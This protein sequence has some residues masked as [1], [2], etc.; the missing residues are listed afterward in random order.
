MVVRSGG[1][2]AR[3]PGDHVA[4]IVALHRVT[5]RLSADAGTAVHARVVDGMRRVSERPASSPSAPAIG[6]VLQPAR[7]GN[8][9]A[10]PSRKSVPIT[11][12]NPAAITETTA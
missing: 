10:C 7:A 8:R 3:V 12:L 2:P 1:G 9:G 4:V 5:I 11:R 6:V